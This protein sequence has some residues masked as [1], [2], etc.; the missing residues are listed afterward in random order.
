MIL[1]TGTGWGMRDATS[2][3]CPGGG[4]AF[5]MCRA[6][7]G[8]VSDVTEEL[9]AQCVSANAPRSNGDSQIVD[10]FAI[11]A[12]CHRWAHKQVAHTR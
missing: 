3:N 8:L 4:S 2:R 5:R 10:I 12:A 9:K 11:T 6:T 1:I 7:G